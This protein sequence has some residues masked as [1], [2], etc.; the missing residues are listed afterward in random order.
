MRQRRA[1]LA[2][3]V[4]LAGAA[5][6]AAPSAA[7]ASAE[8]R[9]ATKVTPGKGQTFHAA[10]QRFTDVSEVPSPERAAEF[11]DALSGCDRVLQRLRGRRPQGLRRARPDR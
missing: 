7:P 3:G 1:A 5:C 6:W 11:Q 4:W 10:V 8:Q 2:A 9:P